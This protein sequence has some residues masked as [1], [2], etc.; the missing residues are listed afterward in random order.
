M[1]RDGWQSLIPGAAIIN[2]PFQIPFDLPDRIVDLLPNL[3][4]LQFYVAEGDLHY[5]ACDTPS[6]SAGCIGGCAKAEKTA[7]PFKR[8][9]NR[10][11]LSWHKMRARASP[12]VIF[13]P[14]ADIDLAFS[15]ISDMHLVFEDTRRIKRI[16]FNQIGDQVWL[17]RRQYLVLVPAFDFFHDFCFIC[18][19]QLAEILAIEENFMVVHRK[20]LRLPVE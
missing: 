19:D 3:L 18:A 15:L 9:C 4:S 12:I 11:V 2:G 6:H 16:L 17:A 5:L 14:M 7:I 8:Y 20:P 13:K 10:H 1:C